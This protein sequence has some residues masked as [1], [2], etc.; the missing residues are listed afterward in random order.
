MNLVSPPSPLQL[1]VSRTQVISVASEITAPTSGDL[2]L[3]CLSG[4]RLVS[5]RWSQAPRQMNTA[6]STGSEVSV[7]RASALAAV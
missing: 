7:S 5:S 6:R 1:G 3:K 2:T 4:C